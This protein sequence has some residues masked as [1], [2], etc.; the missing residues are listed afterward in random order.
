MTISSED[1]ILIPI[2]AKGGC[3]DLRALRNAREI[4]RLKSTTQKQFMKLFVYYYIKETDPD[5]DE[6]MLDCDSDTSQ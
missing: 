5:G 4:A 6:P 1:R 2:V 3:V